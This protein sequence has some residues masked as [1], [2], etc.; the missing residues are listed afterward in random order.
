[1]NFFA[2]ANRFEKVS[3]IFRKFDVELIDTED[4]SR[5]KIN[6]TDS[7]GISPKD[8]TNRIFLPKKCTEFDI[9]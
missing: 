2:I 7:L 9:C 4:R 3:S 6:S 5:E 8:T 1:M